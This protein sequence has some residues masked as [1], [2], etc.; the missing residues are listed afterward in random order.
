L[1]GKGA[2]ADDRIRPRPAGRPATASAT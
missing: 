2:S 1:G